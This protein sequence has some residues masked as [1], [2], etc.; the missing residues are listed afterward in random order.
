MM[1]DSDFCDDVEGFQ[2]VMGDPPTIAGWFLVRENHPSVDSWMMMTGGAPMTCWTPP[3][4]VVD[5]LIEKMGD[6]P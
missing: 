6:V 5:L 2:L 4:F 3:F 1:L